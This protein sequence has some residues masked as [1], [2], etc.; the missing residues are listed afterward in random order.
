MY[1]D[2]AISV[3]GAVLLEPVFTTESLE[4]QIVIIIGLAA[5]LF[6]FCLFL[7]EMAE[8]RQKKQARIRKLEH[9]LE[10]LRGGAKREGRESTASYDTTGD[11]TGYAIDDAG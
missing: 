6:I 4:E 8:K 1:K 3:L 7:D 5:V 11:G 10:N 2:I 9:T